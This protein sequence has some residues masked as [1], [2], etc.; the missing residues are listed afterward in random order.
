MP[1][2]RSSQTARVNSKDTSH[3]L[4]LNTEAQINGRNLR[5]L[6]VYSGGRFIDVTEPRR[7]LDG[8]ST[9]SGL[10]SGAFI[11]LY[12]ADIPAN[13]GK[14]ASVKVEA[15]VTFPGGTNKELQSQTA[16]FG[17]VEI[18]GAP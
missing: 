18:A 9:L 5:D 6:A 2:V 1:F 3:I 8:S 14:S 11:L 12:D 15:T 16:T 13:V 4:N 7:M 10:L 17:T